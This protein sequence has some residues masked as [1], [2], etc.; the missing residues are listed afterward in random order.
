MSPD[1]KISKDQLRHIAK[2]SRLEIKPEEE[3]YL[4]DQLSET[5]SYIDVLQEL[6]TNNVNPTFQVNHKKN[7]LRDDVIKPSLTQEEVLSQAPEKC[8]GYFKTKATIKK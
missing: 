4:V 7:V 8:D 3:D 6:N 1:T 5:A 2:L